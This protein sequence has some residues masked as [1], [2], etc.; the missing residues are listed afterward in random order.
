VQPVRAGWQGRQG[1]FDKIRRCLVGRVCHGIAA[2]VAE[3]MRVGLKSTMRER[4][5]AVSG[6]PRSET[7]T[8]SEPSLSRRWATRDMSLGGSALGPQLVHLSACP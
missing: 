2:S 8:D 6:T 7:N 5:G 4:P 1:G 3:H